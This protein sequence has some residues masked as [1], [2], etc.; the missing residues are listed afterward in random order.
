MIDAGGSPLAADMENVR[1]DPLEADTRSDDDLENEIAELCTHIDAATYRLLRA[2]AEFDRREVWG[3]GFQST[4]HWLS[5]RVG[6]DMV[7]AREKV[8][9]ARALEG[10]PQEVAAVVEKALEAAM[11]LP[12]EEEKKERTDGNDSAESSDRPRDGAM[13]DS[14]ESRRGP[15]GGES[16]IRTR[17]RCE[18]G[19][20]LLGTGNAWIAY[21]RRRA[22]KL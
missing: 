9:V 10:L 3:W 22:D 19:R 21:G 4:A 5:W 1:F 7:T 2:I 20:L 15:E 13:D 16:P 12:R 18:H 6:I 14:A 17:D 11:D 8:R